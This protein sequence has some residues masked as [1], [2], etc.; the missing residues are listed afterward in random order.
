MVLSLQTLPSRIDIE[1]NW[2]CGT[3]R[4]WLARLPKQQSCTKKFEVPRFSQLSISVCNQK[5]E[6]NEGLESRAVSPPGLRGAWVGSVSQ[7]RFSHG[8]PSRQLAS[9]SYQSKVVVERWFCGSYMPVVPHGPTPPWEGAAF[10]RLLCETTF[11][12]F[13]WQLLVHWFWT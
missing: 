13:W 2:C 7:P 3:E 4:V 1:S 5:L 11:L 8:T 6:G 12:P 10:V 9:A